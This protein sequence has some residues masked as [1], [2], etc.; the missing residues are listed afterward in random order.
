MTCSEKAQTV[1]RYVMRGFAPHEI[2]LHMRTGEEDIRHQLQELDTTEQWC[3][4][5][6]QYV[7]ME[8]RRNNR[9]R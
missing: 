3:E 2:A 6:D 7:N 1:R 9:M 8:R 5:L 4:T